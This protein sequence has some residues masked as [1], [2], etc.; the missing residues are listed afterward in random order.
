MPSISVSAKYKR[1]YHK[2]SSGR[3]GKQPVKRYQ[4]RRAFRRFARRIPHP[5]RKYLDAFWGT[6]VTFP[7]TSYVS[8]PY[9]LA[10][11]QSSAQELST[12]PEQGVTQAQM[13][14]YKG[15]WKSMLARW[16]LAV[17]P[18]VTPR[19]RISQSNYLLLEI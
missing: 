15:Q 3:S 19:R 6:S 4:L 18:S 11:I 17:N 8:G 5:Q 9:S 12:D 10:S 16:A 1:R 7:A 2:R 14:G 13:I